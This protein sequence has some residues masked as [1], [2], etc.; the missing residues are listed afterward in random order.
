MNTLKTALLLGLLSI[1]LIYTGGFIGGSQGAT[2]FFLI[3]LAM[4]FSSYWWSDKI[5][6]AMYRAQPIEEK[7]AP[8]LF[9]MVQSLTDNAGIPMPRLYLIPDM[10][11]NA[12]ATGRNPNNAV[13]AVTQGILKM[14]N[15]EELKGVI[16]HE[17]SH[18]K[19][20]DILIGSV[21]ATIAA[22]ITLLARVVG[23][24][25][26][27]GGGNDRREGGN[28][29]LMMILAP[30]AAMII[31]MAVSRSR[32]FQADASAAQLI[33]SPN[34][35]ASALRKLEISAQTYPMH[36]GSSS[37]AHLFIVN[38]FRSSLFQNLFSTH[39]STEERIKRL[40]AV[41]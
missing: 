39:P 6:L 25:A 13:V 12:F 24:S 26:M 15:T 41:H 8:E 20:R 31:Q 18:I 28:P 10:R 19:N 40:L 29:L 4:N 23:Y 11:P 33:G 14:L 1:L 22:T 34:G 27:F 5:V 36:G 35:L 32:E 3:A 38:P 30:I 2:I 21:A 9:R 7:S 37:T 17:L 16:A